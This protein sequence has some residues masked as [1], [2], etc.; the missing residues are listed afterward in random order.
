[1][2]DD[3]PIRGLIDINVHPRRDVCTFCVMKAINASAGASVDSGTPAF[4][5]I[6]WCGGGGWGC[7]GGNCVCG[8]A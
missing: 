3:K 2:R 4:V 5:D 6:G 7:S 8:Q 1:M